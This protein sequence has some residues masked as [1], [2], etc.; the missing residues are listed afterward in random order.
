MKN[1]V[2]RYWTKFVA[3]AAV[4]AG[5]FVAYR[6]YVHFLNKENEESSKKN[7]TKSTKENSNKSSSKKTKK[8]NAPKVDTYLMTSEENPST[9]KPKRVRVKK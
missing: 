1:D 5:I 2:Y 8:S 4:H 6:L 7:S 9:V 3:G